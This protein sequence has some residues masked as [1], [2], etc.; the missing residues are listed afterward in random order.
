MN[1]N[2]LTCYESPYPKRRIGKDYDG[3]YVIIDI[4]DVQ[5]DCLIGAG[6]SDDI[7]FEE[8]LCKMYKDIPC[9]AYD[10]TIESIKTNVE[11]I[12]FIRKNIGSVEN[13]KI[14]NLHSILKQFQNIFVKMDIEGSEIQWLYSLSDEHLQNIA[15]IVMEFHFPF[16]KQ[17]AAVFDKIN[18]NHVLLHFHPN[19]NIHCGVRNHMNVIIPNVFECTYINKKFVNQPYILNRNPIPSD[20]DMR[21]VKEHTDVIINYPPFVN[22]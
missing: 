8:D 20:I 19:N 11:S 12:Q 5:Y 18:S 15:Q 14:T 1:P 10:G 21:N 13:D 3:G 7:S 22:P 2:V 4:P 6:I 16:S 9:Y 17:D